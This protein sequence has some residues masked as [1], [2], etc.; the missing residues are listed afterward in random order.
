MTSPIRGSVS[1]PFT[2]RSTPVSEGAP[3][4]QS[5]SRA[6]RFGTSH[7]VDRPTGLRPGDARIQP[8]PPQFTHLVAR[9]GAQTA[10]AAE[11]VVIT[12]TATPELAVK[13]NSTVT[14]TISIDKDVTL[15]SLKF[16]VDLPHT[17]R[18]DLVATL[19]SPSGKTVTLLNREGGSADDYK[20]TFDISGFAGEKTKGDWKLTV[21]DKARLDEGTLKSWGMEITGHV[22]QPEPKPVSGP[23]VVVVLDGGVDAKHE[24]LDGAMWTNPGEVEGDGIDN[25]NNGVVDDVHGFNVGFNSGDV[26]RGSAVDHGTHIAGIIAAEDN[27]IGVTGVA[28]GKAQVMAVGGLYNGADLLTNF[29]RSVDYIVKM[30]AAGAN[31]RVVN[32]SFGDEYRDVASQNRWKAAIQKLADAD[33]MLCAATANASSNMNDVA[34]MPAN[35]DMPNVITVAAMDKNNDKLADFSS[36]G[37]KVVELAAEGEDIRSTLPGNRYGLMSGTSMATPRVA[38]TAALLFQINPNLTA[39]QAREIILSSIDK[40]SDL[41]GKVSTGGKLNIA[42][43]VEKA[44]ATLPPPAPA[45]ARRAEW[46]LA[47]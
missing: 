28:A 39:A 33:I 38:A 20:G 13:D 18:G 9:P 25:D 27:G 40:D 23:P 26:G 12:A 44:K 43:A 30:K 2:S 5:A 15:D 4:P 10:A 32:A 46:F 11:P 14:S 31:I 41:T 21:S 24:D 35:V 1:A 3:R 36:W 37:D 7:F 45:A 16:T 22:D 42:A 34:D 17:Y 8:P 19:T 47:A 29:E 6:D